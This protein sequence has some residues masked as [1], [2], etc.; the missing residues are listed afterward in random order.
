MKARLFVFLLALVAATATPAAAVAQAPVAPGNAAQ[1]SQRQAAYGWEKQDKGPDLL[2][3]SFSFVDIADA[4]IRQKLSSGLTSVI[5]MRAYA[6][7]DGNA[8]PVALAARTCR[9]AYDLWDEVY[10]LKI[11][12]P[13]GERD[14]AALN[15]EGVLRQCFEARKL[16]VAD[17]S[18]LVSGKPHFLGV[19][20][21]VNPVNAQMVEEM[22][23][24]VSRPAGSTGIG[25]A[26]ALFGS[27]VGLLMRQTGTADR[28]LRFRTQSITP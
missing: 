12:G 22:R 9:V 13:G 14:G 11:S 3:A 2:V 16:T 23:K 10:R 1:L 6:F 19:I 4:G 21:E 28:T 18:L 24:W 8:D 27:F 17:R 15:I 26:D 5:V 20:V 25:P 7:R